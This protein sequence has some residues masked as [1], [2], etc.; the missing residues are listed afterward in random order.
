MGLDFSRFAGLVGRS[1]GLLARA[2]FDNANVGLGIA[3][4][5]EQLLAECRRLAIAAVT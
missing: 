1:N 3:F 2:L 4:C 5:P